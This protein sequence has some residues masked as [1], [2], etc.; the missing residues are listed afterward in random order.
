[1]LFHL[2]YIIPLIGNFAKYW[3]LKCY[4]SISRVNFLQKK[5]NG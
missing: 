3:D 5:I 1:M 4:V 2:K